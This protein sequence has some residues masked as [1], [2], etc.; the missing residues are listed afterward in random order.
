MACALKFT[1]DKSSLRTTF[2][3]SC[4]VTMNRRDMTQLGATIL[5]EFVEQIRVS[6]RPANSRSG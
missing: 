2:P 3:A 1:L 5:R 4:P 6:D